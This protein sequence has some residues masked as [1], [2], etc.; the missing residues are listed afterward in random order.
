MPRR[1]VANAVE[2][3][4]YSTVEAT[5]GIDAVEIY[6]A[7]REEIRGIVLDMVMPQMSG[8]A[9][10]VALR[11][12]DPSVPVLLM[13]GYAVNEEVQAILDLGVK[14]FVAKPHSVEQLAEAL[15]VALQR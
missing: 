1:A 14:A 3:L 12:I 4:G 6:R 13:S 5:S 10:Y 11:E 9:T 8:R 2:T 7:H 15:S